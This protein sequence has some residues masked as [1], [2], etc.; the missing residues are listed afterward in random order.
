[1]VERI[2]V[3]SDTHGVEPCVRAVLA[4]PEVQAADLVVVTGDLAA[5]PQPTQ[6]L[7]ALVALGERG[8]LVRGNADRD[9]VTIARGGTPP[10]G[11][12]AV[13]WLAAGQLP[14]SYVEL[15]G[16]LPHPVVLELA[17]LGAVMCCH[18]S[19]RDDDE[20]VL[21][22]TRPARWAEVLADV[23]DEVRVVCCGHTHMPS[24]RLVDRRWVV[25]SGSVGMPYGSTGIPWV[26]LDAKGVQLRSTAIDARAVAAQVIADSAFPGVAAW[27]EEYVLNPPSDVDAVLAFAGRDGRPADWNAG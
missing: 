7:D 2:A 9:L 25:N 14:S 12:P 13:D 4:E 6:V 17:G 24:V 18:G 10:G 8:V 23:P 11:T 26:L 3:L 16:G 1:M 19:P 5:G 21:V 22:D 27:V 15:L 20:V